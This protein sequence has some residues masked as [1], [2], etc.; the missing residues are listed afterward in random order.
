MEEED[1]RESTA[2]KSAEENRDMLATSRLPP[3]LLL[4]PLPL[5]G[6]ATSIIIMEEESPG[7]VEMG[8]ASALL[9][10]MDTAA[11][12]GWGFITSSCC[13]CCCCCCSNCNCCVVTAESCRCLLSPWPSSG[14][15]TDGLD[16]WLSPL[17]LLLVL[18]L[19]LPVPASCMSKP[20]K[21]PVERT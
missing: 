19:L 9:L 3:L 11:K 15:A 13:C 14:Y 21:E 7:M 16:P 12:C 8:R 6:E 10:R 1:R 17:P 4:A 2:G 5:P 20:A 18:L